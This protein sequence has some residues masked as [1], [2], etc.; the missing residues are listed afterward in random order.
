MLTPFAD[1]PVRLRIE[2]GESMVGYM[3][4]FYAANGHKMPRELYNA[5]RP[6]YR[7]TQGTAAV[8]FDLVQSML[9]A[10]VTLDRSWWL[11]RQLHKGYPH[12]GGYPPAWLTLS[13]GPLRLCPACL[14]DS[15]IYFALWELPLME[16]CPLHH[17]ALLTACP[18]CSRTFHWQDWL[19]NWH[20]QCGVDITTIPLVLPKS[21]TV[22]VAQ[23]LVG[24]SD[25]ILPKLYQQHSIALNHDQY[26]VEEVYKGLAWGTSLRDLFFKCGSRAGE[27]NVNR[28]PIRKRRERRGFWER[29]LIGDSTDK[30]ISRLVRA[31]KKHFN[32]PQLLNYVFPSDGLAQAKAFVRESS[33]GVVKTKIQKTLDRFL[34]DYALELALSLFVWFLDARHSEQRLAY[35]R[36]FAAWWAILATRIGDL[37]PVIQRHDFEST[38][39]ARAHDASLREVHVVEVLNLLFEGAR[40]QL[41]VENFRGLTYWWRIPPALRDVSEPEE[42]FRSVGLHLASVP[43]G[44][45]LFVLDL[46]QRAHKGG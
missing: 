28:R 6:L 41:S 19:P 3:R 46:V 39:Q 29:R 23:V 37:D 32:T 13:L 12:H 31:Q 45:I 18:A 35:M 5:M 27:L 26:H 11:G 8:A 34:V 16:A 9:G 1:Y 10:L 30:L 21:G 44:E 2:E 17:C 40:Q 33:P 43:L 20:C 7:G 24:S 15:G 25:L 14:Q 36:Q 22:E 42:L 4:R 38:K